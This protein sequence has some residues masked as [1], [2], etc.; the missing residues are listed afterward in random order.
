MSRCEWKL[1]TVSTACVWFPT[2]AVAWLCTNSKFLTRPF[3][4]TNDA[5]NEA[6]HWTRQ[7]IDIKMC[8]ELLWMIVCGLWMYNFMLCCM[9]Q[10][11]DLYLLSTTCSH[12]K[13]LARPLP[14]EETSCYTRWQKAGAEYLWLQFQRNWVWLEPVGCL[15]GHDIQQKE[16]AQAIRWLFEVCVGFLIAEGF[17]RVPA[18]SLKPFKISAP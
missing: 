14:S 10:I 11:F 1:F 9:M 3:F 18:E 8:S 2:F 16:A 17:E 5:I 12:T 7:Q 13:S 15:I 4:A 6:Q